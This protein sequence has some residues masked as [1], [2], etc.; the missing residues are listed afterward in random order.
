M[1]APTEESNGRNP[2]LDAALAYLRAG[3][4]VIPIRPD[5]SK[6]PE[7]EWKPYQQ[8]RAEADQLERWFGEGRSGPAI[9]GGTVSGG[10]EVL[11]VED[12]ETFLAWHQLAEAE[13]PG[14]VGRLPR[15]CTPGGGAHVYYRCGRPEGNRKLALD[16]RGEVLAETRAAGGYVLA[17]GCPAGCHETGRPYEWVDGLPGDIPRVSDEERAVLLAAA[18]SLNRHVRPAVTWDTPPAAGGGARPGDDFCRRAGWGEVLEPNGWAAVG[19][20]GETALWRRPGKQGRVWS[21]TTGHCHSEAG[22]DLLYV[23]SSSAAPFEAGRSYS[24][25][26]AYAL[27]NHSGDYKAAARALAGQG[28]GEQR[29]PPPSGAAGNGQAG[30]ES[31]PRKSAATR[32]VELAEGAGVEL[33]HAPDQAAYAGLAPGGRRETWPLKSTGF[34]RWLAR[35]FY[36]CEGKAAGAQA[37]ADALA[38]LESRALFDG[39]EAPVSVRLAEHGGRTYLDLADPGW[40]VVEVDAAGWRVLDRSPVRFRRPRGL[41]PLPA[42]SAGGSVAEL[43]PF[44]NV[45]SDDD[46]RLL[47]AWL[48]QA[49]RPSGPYPVLC[50]TG[51]HGSAKSTAAR[52][53][54]SLTDPNVVMLRKEPRDD[55]DLLIAATNSWVTAFD[56]L[57]HIPPWLSD[58]L[59]RLATGGG[60]TTRQLYTDDEEALFDATRPVILT[61]IE[62]L[63]TRGDLLDRCLLL[64]LPV[65]PDTVRQPERVF[66]REFEAAR[67]RILGALLDAVGGALREL[68]RVNLPGLPRM[69]DFAEWATAA[70]PSLGWREGDF[71]GAYL[72]NR[73]GANEVAL[74][75]DVVVAPLRKFIDRGGAWAGSASELLAELAGL[76][77]EAACRAPEWP[78]RPNALSGRLRRLAPNLLAAGYAVTFERAAGGKRPRLIRLGKSE[79]KAGER[80]SLSSRG[81]ENQ[82]ENAPPPGTVGDGP[83]GGRDDPRDDV[84]AT[85]DGRDDGDDLSAACSRDDLYEYGD[86]FP[87]KGGA[88]S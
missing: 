14:L 24:K 44:V 38:V 81:A 35:L 36:E 32:L 12:A 34:R 54:R 57:S 59:S 13:C 28:Y 31:P 52:A 21:A 3:L 16:E 72:G 56:N 61:S 30:A 63:A 53:L 2:A 73:A 18:E 84:R 88:D 74:D 80:S 10:L 29:R 45:A 66:W 33:F 68:P 23:F 87:G 8:R 67:P 1:A 27:L 46:F 75:A 86:P 20:S 65:I 6:R 76:A 50:L 11:D 7:C 9:V 47:V 64:N 60:V 5:G 15:V 71:M 4:S 83:D 48:V 43:T 77:G 79:E 26:A 70:G 17:P 40:R 82:G 85:Q 69:A 22:G 62:D 78:R 49:L 58:A 39:A 41:L 25:F 37:V 19:R 55:R 51:Q 42:P